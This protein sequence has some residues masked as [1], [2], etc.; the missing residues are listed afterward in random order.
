MQK[1]PTNLL[2]LQNLMKRDPG[3]YEAEMR[4][5]WQRF[6]HQLRL[7]QLDS[8]SLQ[9]PHLLKDFTSLLSFLSHVASCFP[10]I[11]A[12][13]PQ[14]LLQLLTAHATALPPSLRL[15]LTQALILL[16]NRGLLS[17]FTLLPALFSLFAVGDKP[18]RALL[19][20]H[21]VAD[22]CRVNRRRK[23]V[24]LNSSLQTF[25]YGLLAEDERS[26]PGPAQDE[27]SMAAKQSLDVMVELWRRRV[28][29][30][31]KTVNVIASA[32]FSPRVRILVTALRF[33]LGL[34]FYDDDEQQD[35]D[36]EQEKKAQSRRQLTD[37]KG[38]VKRRKRRERQVKRAVKKLQH[39]RRSRSEQQHSDV[40]AIQ[41]LH[42]PQAFAERLFSRLRSSSHSFPVR[43]L[44][45]NVLSRLIGAPLAAAAQLLPLRGA[46][47][48]AAPA[49]RHLAAGLPGAGLPP[50]RPA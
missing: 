7:L 40:A 31:A 27:D 14:H 16:Q 29:T 12:P 45:M 1:H 36:E 25:M 47:P 13:L 50:A 4:Q 6:Q 38:V 33:F 43:L 15:S 21:I 20:R 17:R 28:W 9:Q 26:V 39:D 30:D 23:D 49:A 5:Q 35:S 24:K 44:T 34:S 18:L 2:N 32:C 19:H 22:I 3:S 8:Q 37:M 42:D 10:V 48:A 41:L 46:L 11:A